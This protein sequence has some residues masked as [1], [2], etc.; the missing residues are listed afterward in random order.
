MQIT[1]QPHFD[2]ATIKSIM[3]RVADWQIANPNKEAEHDDLD[4]THAALYMGMLDW[5]ELAE[6][7]DSDDSYYQWLLH[8]GQR[9]HFQVGKWMYHA[10]F[11]A[12]GQPFIDLYIKYGNKKMIAPV[13]ARAN[14]VVENPAK[15]TLKLDYRK[16][17]TLD[18]WSWCDA[19]FMAPPV[20]AK[21][22]A[23]TKKK[24]Y[25]YFLNKEYKATYD[26]LY[27]KEE[28]L[29]YRD[30]RYFDKHEANGKKVFWGRGNGWV[31]GGLVKILQ[32]LPGDEPSRT[33][34]HNLFV[35]LATR[36][37]G[38]QSPD[39]YWHASLLDP[40]SYPSPETSATGFIVYALAYGVNMGL[41]NK[42]TFMPVIEK[43][44]K[45]LVAA[46]DS[47]GKLGYVQ[48][49]GADPRK[50]TRNMTEVYGVG[51]FLLSGCQI[52][53]MADKE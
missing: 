20:Y 34:Y 13:M 12:V 44:W 3:K 26:Y 22:Y 27:D 46:V 1:A 25:L 17:E 10:D 30:R 8:I 15:T 11:I 36:M 52:Y 53:K 5:A 45:A 51:A 41:L 9:N 14:W 29:F 38:L 42:T 6:K 37:A 4:W 43:G 49:I 31:L 47:D 48:P 39:G 33:F 16:L 32:A 24:K 2:R 7:E 28:R 21:L 40:V 50:V 35:T 23:L 18:R 19:L